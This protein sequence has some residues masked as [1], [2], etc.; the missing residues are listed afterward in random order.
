VAAESPLRQ[1]AIDEYAAAKA[2]EPLISHPEERDLYQ[3][4]SSELRNTSRDSDRGMALLAAS[5][6]RRCVGSSSCPTP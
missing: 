6:D 3:K 4:M 1:K 5:Q 2:Y